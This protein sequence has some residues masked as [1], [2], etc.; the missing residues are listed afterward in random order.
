MAVWPLH[1]SGPLSYRQYL[2]LTPP[3][4]FWLHSPATAGSSGAMYEKGLDG[5]KLK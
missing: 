5:I 1:G 2:C 4:N 3:D